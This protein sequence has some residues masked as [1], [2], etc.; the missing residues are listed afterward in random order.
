MHRS[1]AP[2]AR[3][4]P[5]LVLIACMTAG[6][7][8][9]PDSPAKVAAGPVTAARSDA[10][11]ALPKPPQAR[12]QR[13]L[14]GKLEDCVA[15]W[16]FAGKCAPVGGDLPERARGAV[17]MGPI[18]SNALRFEAQLATRREAFDQGY[19]PQVDE[20]PSNRSIATSEVRS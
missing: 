19:V 14:Y 8:R 16:A 6:C 3:A 7:S 13:D 20:N 4:F 1:I 5:F 12:Y 17:F 11:P 9:V 15:D 18:Y 2:A 10:A